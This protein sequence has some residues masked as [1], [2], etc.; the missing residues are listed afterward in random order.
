MTGFPQTRDQLE[1]VA[2]KRGGRSG[3]KGERDAAERL[4]A[5]QN[6]NGPSLE[7]RNVTT[8]IALGNR[9]FVFIGPQFPCPVS[10]YCVSPQ[11]RVAGRAAGVGV[12]PPSFPWR[13]TWRRLRK[14]SQRSARF[15]CGSFCRTCSPWAA[16]IRISAQPADAPCRS[17]GPSRAHYDSS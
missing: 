17:R 11:P 2:K 7:L 5:F 15:A 12:R 3:I 1:A 10:P 13:N 14:F 6:R 8:G 9:S 16:S 4:A